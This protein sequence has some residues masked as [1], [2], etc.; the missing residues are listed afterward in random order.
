MSI[1]QL[2]N[3]PV[4]QLS[5]L[6]ARQRSMDIKNQLQVGLTLTTFSGKFASCA[7]WIPKLWS[8]TPSSQSFRET[9]SWSGKSKRTWFNLVQERDIS[10][11]RRRCIF[12]V[13]VSYNMKIFDVRKLLIEGSQ[14]V[15]VSG[16]Q[17]ESPDLRC[18]VPL[19]SIRYQQKWKTSSLTQI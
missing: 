9:S 15:K 4:H 1:H 10:F 3:L 19:D 18:Y 17:A 5:V 11:A 13:H 8:E 2:Q 14:F 7:T 6:R 12:L 16:K